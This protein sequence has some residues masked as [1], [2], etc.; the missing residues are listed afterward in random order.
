MTGYTIHLGNQ[1]WGTHWQ[2]ESIGNRIDQ[3]EPESSGLQDERPDELIPI[4]KLDFTARMHTMASVLDCDEAQVTKLIAGMSHKV[5]AVNWIQDSED[6]EQYILYQLWQA[7]KR[8]AGNWD[9][10][11]LEI[12]GAYKSWWTTYTRQHTSTEMDLVSFQREIV[13][14]DITVESQDGRECQELA[15][16]DTQDMVNRV[17][18]AVP[19]NIRKI[20][21]LRLNNA[22]LTARERQQW[23][24]YMKVNGEEI[25]SLVTVS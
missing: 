24:R 2:R 5:K 19:A 25:K 6:L 8:I 10:I 17:L 21:Q 23:S 12:S 7:R 20:I 11:K 3:V 22:A 14:E 1:I 13:L 9:L 4:R 15:D 18:V 16:V